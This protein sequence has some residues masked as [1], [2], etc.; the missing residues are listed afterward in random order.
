M[1]NFGAKYPPNSKTPW[2]STTSGIRIRS[3]KRTGIRKDK[4]SYQQQI[5]KILDTVIRVLEISG[6]GE[7]R[8]QIK[9][10]HQAITES[11]QR[12]AKCHEQLLSAPPEASLAVWE[13]PWKAK[14]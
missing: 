11:Q 8:K 5:E 10:L 3:P 13:K 9:T 6:A 14:P 7:C 2:D 1:S 12:L 4:A